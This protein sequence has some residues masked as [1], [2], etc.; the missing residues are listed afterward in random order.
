MTAYAVWPVASLSSSTA[1]LVMA[2]VTIDPPMSMRTCAVVWPF[3]TST[4]LPLRM[5]RALSFTETSCCG[6][7]V[8]ITS[9]RADC[10]NCPR[11]AFDRAIELDDAFAHRREC[12]ATAL[13]PAR[14][15]R[16]RRL[17]QGIIELL[18][19]QPG[20]PIGHVEAACRRRNRSGLPDRLQQGDLAGTDAVPAR[21]VE[22][23]AEASVRHGFGMPATIV[24]RTPRRCCCRQGAWARRWTGGARVL[25][26]DFRLRRARPDSAGDQ[27][28][29]RPIPDLNR[30]GVRTAQ[31]SCRPRPR[32]SSRRPARA[33]S[34]AWS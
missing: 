7:S 17:L 26:S 6:W 18:H 20:P 21:Q 25:D 3:F 27:R 11:D 23:D 32:R 1:S 30:T 15:G 16:D 19:Q 14:C 5:L 8:S 10:E 13:A 34:P 29:A 33:A 2:D 31:R 28:R 24:T 12:S 4:I 22:T 9:T